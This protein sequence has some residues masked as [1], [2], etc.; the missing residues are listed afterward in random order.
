MTTEKMD[1][2]IS[3]L[4][5]D[6]VISDPGALEKYASAGLVRGFVPSCAV[7]VKDGFEIQKLVKLANE[8]GIKLIPASSSDD[9]RNG[10][11]VPFV[12]DA[13]IV[14]LSGMKNIVL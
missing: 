5:P 2:I 3:L 6:R 1:K 14:D 7:K 10:G 8:E 9:H 12:Q 4:D 13:V 11:T